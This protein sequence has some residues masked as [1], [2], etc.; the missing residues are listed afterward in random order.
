MGIQNPPVYWDAMTF[1][2]AW[3]WGTI[4]MGNG[5][6]PTNAGLKTPQVE[7]MVIPLLQKL[8]YHVQPYTDSHMGENLYRG[9]LGSTSPFPHLWLRTLYLSRSS[10][11]S[12]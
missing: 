12:A 9:P 7:R 1:C 5:V 2:S 4:N 10:L 8:L 6:P 11:G 3:G